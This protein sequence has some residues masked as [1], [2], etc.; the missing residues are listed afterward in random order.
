MDT[1]EETAVNILMNPIVA[2][3]IN[4]KPTTHGA[5]VLYNTVS[6]ALSIV[7]QFF[8]VMAFNGVSSELNLFSKLPPR[9]N[10]LIRMGLATLYTFVGSLC[11][12]G[13]VCALKEGWD[14]NG[15]QFVLS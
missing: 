9:T 6:V 10:G 3:S 15:A 14:V 7:R 2:S 12:M 4:I 11:W 1:S 8:F 5:R 13:Y